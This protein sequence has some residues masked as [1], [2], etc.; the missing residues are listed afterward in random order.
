MSAPSGVI[1]VLLSTAETSAAILFFPVQPITGQHADAIAAECPGLFEVEGK[2]KSK[3][4][5]VNPAREHVQ[6][7]EKVYSIPHIIC[8]SQLDIIV[9]VLFSV[10]TES[11]A[12]A[13]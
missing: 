10:R 8:C 3:K 12:R 4:A 13:R 7:L 11:D 1:L 9:Y 2:G 6:L 5:K